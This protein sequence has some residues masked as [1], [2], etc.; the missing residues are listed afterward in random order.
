MKKLMLF[1]SLTAFIF[2]GCN[3]DNNIVEPDAAISKAGKTDVTWIQLPAAKEGSLRKDVLVSQE[4]LGSEGAVLSINDSYEG[5][6][7]PVTIEASL[8][9]LPGA[10]DSTRFISMSINDLFGE[11]TFSPHGV[12][13]LPAIYNLTITGIDLTGVNPENVSF[14]YLSPD[15]TYETI[16]NDGLN[17]DIPTGTLEVINAQLPHFSRYGYTNDPIE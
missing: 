16:V 17:V 2:F 15:G 1:A 5:V 3:T 8:E 11:T 12:F 7:G 9:F 6:N 4:V 10:F 13:Y 14:V